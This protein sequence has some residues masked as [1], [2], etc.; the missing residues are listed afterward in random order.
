MILLF[1][2]QQ[3]FRPPDKGVLPKILSSKFLVFIGII[4]YSI[5]LSHTPVI[6]IMRPLFNL[7]HLP[8]D[9]FYAFATF[10]VTACIS[11]TLYHLLE[12]PYF[13]KKDVK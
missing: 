12:K 8:G 13:I 2:A 6:H 4:S 1:N 10:L 5:Y 7:R 3:H 9:F 11:F